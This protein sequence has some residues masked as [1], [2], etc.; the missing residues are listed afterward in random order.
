[1]AIIPRLTAPHTTPDTGPARDNRRGA[2]WLLTDMCFNVWALAIAKSLGMDLPPIQIVLVRALVGLALLVPF[3]VYNGGMVRLTNPRLQVMR[4]LL[5]TIA[6]TGN[7]FAV[8]KLPF[9]LFTTVNFTRPLLMM[10]LAAWLLRERIL[11]KQWL[12]GG[13]G[14]IGV[15]IAVDPFSLG[16]SSLGG[17]AA[18]FASVVAGTIAVI[19]LRRLRNEDALAQMIW[20]TAGLS[21][22]ALIPAAYFWQPPGAHWPILVAIGLFSQTAQFCFMRA[23]YWADAGVIAP[24]GYASLILSVSVGY[25]VFH[26]VP[27]TGL[28][29]G[30]AL[31]I[32]AALMAGNRRKRP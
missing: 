24:L 15:A 30:A 26:E 2:L 28:Y 27:T 5:S 3:V 22:A 17:L 6:M 20:Q 31:I 13:I 12:A 32:G 14:L 29:F 4:T 25:F 19:I 23:H 1:M 18:L 11:P 16:A 7:F 9:A 10:T 21:L 8:A